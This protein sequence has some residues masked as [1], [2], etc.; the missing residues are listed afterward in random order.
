MTYNLTVLVQLISATLPALA[1]MWMLILLLPFAVPFTL[2]LC[3]IVKAKACCNKRRQ[4]APTAVEQPMQK[5]MTLFTSHEIKMVLL[6]T[7]NNISAP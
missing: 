3:S 4:R 6:N 1:C 2:K 5:S 7:Q